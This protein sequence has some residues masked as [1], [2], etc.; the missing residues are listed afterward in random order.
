MTCRMI[1][2]MARSPKST[3]P[4]KSSLGNIV[5]VRL[6]H[7]LAFAMRRF[8]WSPDDYQGDVERREWWA[9]AWQRHPRVKA[10]PVKEPPSDER[11]EAA[12]D[13]LLAVDRALTQGGDDDWADLR[14]M[15]D[16][17]LK[18]DARSRARILGWCARAIYQV[19][20]ATGT[21]QREA[22]RMSATILVGQ[23]RSVDSAYER[24]TEGRVAEEL[25][26]GYW[27]V[28]PSGA[29]RA[30]PAAFAWHISQA[31]EDVAAEQ[32]AAFPDGGSARWRQCLDH[33]VAERVFH[34][35]RRHLLA[36]T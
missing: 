16:T 28:A 9:E 1:F 33:D 25:R 7:F 27:P 13:V 18:S 23:L 12:L 36:A 21:S 22:T 2:D 3:E 4:T 24:L 34:D 31:C 5:G 19:H 29:G 26:K 6:H 17:T 14:L 15:R 20:K 8:G 30:G 11:L 10:A 32:R 35:L